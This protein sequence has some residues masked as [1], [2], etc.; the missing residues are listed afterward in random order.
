MDYPAIEKNINA[1]IRDKFTNA[2]TNIA[3]MHLHHGLE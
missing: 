1:P 3:H 2:W